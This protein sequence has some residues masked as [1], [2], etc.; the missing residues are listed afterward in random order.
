MVIPTSSGSHQ[1][2]LPIMFFSNSFKAIFD[3][4][5]CCDNNVSPST[6]FSG[7]QKC[8][9]SKVA[10]RGFTLIELLVVIGIIAILAGLLLPVLASAREKGRSAQCMNN[11]KQI[12]DATMIYLND[13]EY[14]PPGHVAG[15]TEWDLCIGGNAGGINDPLSSDARSKVFACPSVIVPED[16]IKLNYSA[17]PNVCKEITTGVGPVKPSSIRRISEIILAADAIQYTSDG[18]SHA[19]F[20]GI[21]GSS[22]SAVSWNNGSSANADQPIPI[23]PDAD[24]VLAVTD[25]NGSNL[26]YRHGKTGVNSLF[27][28]T[29]VDRIRKGRVLDRNLYTDY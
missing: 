9:A 5:A 8:P 17:N 16:G 6:L 25:P 29:H 26:R 7:T 28:D 4:I 3:D 24:A 12:G 15:V 11:L 20:W 23:G 10:A 2:L 1:W 19:I 14:Y 27:I 13:F 18:N 22:G 21:N